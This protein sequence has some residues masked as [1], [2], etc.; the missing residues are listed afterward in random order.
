MGK[1]RAM[2]RAGERRRVRLGGAKEDPCPATNE[3]VVPADPEHVSDANRHATSEPLGVEPAHSS[4]LNGDSCSGTGEALVPVEPE[5][6][7]GSNGATRPAPKETAEPAH[8]EHISDA[9]GSSALATSEPLD[10][11]PAHKSGL[12]GDLCSGTGETLAPVEPE[13]VSGSNGATRPAPK[14]TAE[15]AHPEH[16]SGPNGDSRPPTRESLSAMLKG[17]SSIS[18][19][20]VES[21]PTFSRKWPTPAEPF[22]PSRDAESPNGFRHLALFAQEESRLVF[23][24]DPDGLAA[25][26][27]R[28]LRRTLSR[29][30]DAGAVLLI[31]SPAMGDGK[32]LTS[33]NLCT[34]LAET[35]N[36][37]L[38][39]E[40][41]V[42]RP[43][44]G[45]FL[46]RGIEPPGLEDALAGKVEPR[47]VV[48]G[49]RELNLYAAM[50]AQIPDSPSQLMSGPGI[51]QF[52]AWARKHFLWVV[53]DAPPV[54]PAADVPELL[55][56]ADAALLVVR[57]QSTPR[58]LTKRAIETLGKHLRGVIFNEVT[59]DSDPHYRYISHYRYPQKTA[60]KLGNQNQ[61]RE[62]EA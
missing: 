50:V 39:V 28:L 31:T 44:I 45:E 60:A 22:R 38:L 61:Y 23:P 57:A 62:Q 52:L 7:S 41:D 34:C 56:F 26:Q 8:P 37:T 24:F 2:G 59:V 43:K 15:P 11:D 17:P 14:E 20:A 53:L 4:G 27:F 16:I 36:P 6:V 46:S 1:I 29:E 40:M 9:D 32:T 49:I 18:P 55:P 48:Y 13:F 19:P 12:D 30:F 35:G 10:I 58:E 3:T 54:L 5:F 51:K 42:R 25:E 33:V 21:I 47:S